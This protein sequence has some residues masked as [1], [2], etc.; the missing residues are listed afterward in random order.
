M[1]W[2]FATASLDYFRENLTET[3][4]LLIEGLSDAPKTLLLKVL[5]EKTK[6]NILVLTAEIRSSKVMD[7]AAFFDLK[8]VFE[9]SPWET[10]PGEEIPPSPDIVG[11]RLETLH[12][13]LTSKTPSVIIC[14]LQA[15]LQK[16]PSPAFF[17]PLCKI[18]KVGDEVP[19]SD[20]PKLLAELGY[21][22]SSVVA[23]KGE[24]AVR[25]GIIDIFPVSA[26]GPYRLEFF[27]DTIDNI[28]SFDPVGQKSITKVKEFFLSPAHEGTEEI[29]TLLAYLG[30]CIIIFDQ[31]LE[32]E[33]RWVSLQQLPGMKTRLMVTF[34]ELLQEMK[35]HQTLFWSDKPIEDLSDVRLGK[36]TG[37]AFYTGTNPLQPLTFECFAKTFETARW[38]SP[39][40]PLSLE[41]PDLDIRFVCEHEAEEHM[42]R[43]E[44][45]KI[46]HPH[47]IKGY[48]SGGFGLVDSTL[49]IVPITELTHRQKVRREKWRSTYHTPPSDFHELIPGDLV[50]HFNH[51]IGK[52]Q[53]M[54]KRPNHQGVITEYLL[55]EYSDNSKLFVPVSQAYLVSRYIGTKEE[56]PVLHTLGTK[57]W[58]RAKATAQKAIVGYA[59]DL[60]RMNAEREVHGGFLYPQDSSDFL[61]F[62][63]EFPYPETEDQLRAIF[64]IK[65]D[66]VSQK[67]MDRLLCGDVGYG[68]TEVAMRAAFKAVVDGKKQV[69]VLVPTTVLALQHYQT[70]L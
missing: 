56:T 27:G 33:D 55:L 64:D 16:V 9:F 44:F 13:L 18:W 63:E 40:T 12:H 52:Y 68:K 24:F 31:L 46:A 37:R 42:I 17:K 29:S 5:Q 35:N 66:M 10:L 2:S 48:L 30:D 67:A 28:R 21:R 19:F 61:Q 26:P 6:K 39:F 43:K 7:N 58:Q 59:Q 25:G 23:D 3:P 69:A 60:L 32:L 36:K 8:G 20:L 57:N 54:E 22:R 1:N 11:K 49:T 45:P 53:G 41:R 70:F 4:S 38:R 15:I 51:G 47:F 14:P 50:V 34:P 62:E 65:Q